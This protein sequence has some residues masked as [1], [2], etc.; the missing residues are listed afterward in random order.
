MQPK[1][2]YQ[3]IAY[4]AP[5]RGWNTRAPENMIPSSDSP[6]INN[7]IFRNAEI[8]SAPRFK[9]AI[10]HPPNAAT[11]IKVIHSFVDSNGVAH[12]VA[13]NSSDLYQLIY[14]SV[15]P[16]GEGNWLWNLVQNFNAGRSGQIFDIKTFLNKIYWTSGTVNK[17]WSWDGIAQTVSEA[18]NKYGG[19]FLGELGFHLILL[20][21][22]EDDAGDIVPFP[23]R[24]RWTPSGLPN[25]WD[26]V[27]NPGAGFNDMLDVPEAITGFLTIGRVGY[28]FRANGISQMTLTGQGARPFN[29]DHL[30][31]SDKGIGNIYH[32]TIS[33]YGSVGMF[34]STEDIYK[35]TPRSFDNVGMGARDKILN[36]LSDATYLPT[37]SILPNYN[38]KY[39]WLTYHLFIPQGNNCIVWFFNIEDNTWSRRI[40]E[41]GFPT[42]KIKSVLI[43]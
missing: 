3:E 15:P 16:P 37:A 5:Y 21:T 17:V 39:I 4:R 10:P 2:Q 18:T 42:G 43:K 6:F 11:A 35:L 41:S 14:R 7:F 8:L 34:I 22:L 9:V 38:Q 20:N 26:P 25:V 24:V 36:D 31:A 19:Y 33:S 40:L 32:Q 12:T 30:W 13:I 23:Q 29:F 1:P 28:I 27:S